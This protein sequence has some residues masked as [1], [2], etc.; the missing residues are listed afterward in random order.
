MKVLI[1]CL[2]I[3]SFLSATNLSLVK[4]TDQE[5]EIEFNL[6]QYNLEEITA[7]GQ[8]FQKIILPGVN[9]S[10]QNLG[11]PELPLMIKTLAI[12]ENA[13]VSI[14]IISA[15]YQEIK[16]AYKIWPHQRPEI[17]Y[18]NTQ[19]EFIIDEAIYQENTFLFEKI[20][21]ISKPMVWRDLRIIHLKIAPILYNPAIQRIRLYKNIR[22]R[23][24]FSQPF[25]RM[26]IS[27]KWLKLYQSII[28]NFSQVPYSLTSENDFYLTVV[29]Q[30]FANS[31]D[32][33][34][35]FYQSK[36]IQ[37]EKLIVDASWTPEQI[38]TEILVRYQNNGL[39]WVLLV[40]DAEHIKPYW[41]EITYDSLPSDAYFSF[42]DGDDFY[43]EIGIGRLSGKNNEEISYQVEKIVN[44]QKFAD[45]PWLN[46]SILIAHREEYPGKYSACKR[47]IYNTT[48]SFCKPEMDTLFAAC[49]ATNDDVISAIDEGVGVVNYRGHGS[50][51][52]WA[53][54][55]V[56]D[57]RA[58]EI[59]QLE[60]GNMTPIVFNIACYNHKFYWPDSNCLGEAWVK[61]YPGGAVASLGAT[62]PSY[63]VVNH[64]YDKILYQAIYEKGILP[65][66][67]VSNL[68]AA[69]II[70]HHGQYGEENVK[71]YC[72]FG[73]PA[74]QV[75]F[76]QS[77]YQPA[78]PSE[79]RL[80]CFPNP[81]FQKV[82]VKYYLPTKSKI[83]LKIYDLS[84][85][86]VTVLNEQEKVK[87]GYHQIF[88]NGQDNCGRKVLSG[89][90]FINLQVEDLKSGARI[91]KRTKIVWLK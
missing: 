44:Y 58:K 52:G 10:S 15:E 8:I 89:I 91:I 14:E 4:N 85:R 78:Y 70:E 48:Y 46:K 18:L 60:N 45:G 29:Y 34:I 64:D 86:L 21:E 76:N 27:P 63:T 68:A 5:L 2:T 41:Y 16:V 26:N 39:D 88:W 66:G 3:F 79:V 36:N 11:Q 37:V 20:V 32:S 82:A 56:R 59:D 42:L 47:S 1:F 43:A 22:L 33:L 19:Q 28:F 7:Q 13:S 67:L 50:T 81:A 83:C 55:C 62:N 80:N 73:D 69:Y 30:D 54:W 25:S 74:M 84:G 17:D 72:W 51:R 9:G 87:K 77:N 49:G 71:M 38:K 90:Y 53:G 12:P 75:K 57:W 24:N 65:I 40:G 61:K 35:N 23:I 6:D 31:V